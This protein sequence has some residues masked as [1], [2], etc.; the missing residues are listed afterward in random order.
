[1]Q[2]RG[3]TLKSIFAAMFKRIPVDRIFRFLDET[4]SW[5]DNTLFIAAMPPRPFLQ[6]LYEQALSAL[7]ATLKIKTAQRRLRAHL[8]A[9]LRLNT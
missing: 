2:Q 5:A 1:M 7:L 9:W 3:D 6:A 8:T 4:S